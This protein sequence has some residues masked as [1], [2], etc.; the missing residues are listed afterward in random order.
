MKTIIQIFVVTLCLA[1]LGQSCLQASE[2]KIDF[3]KK[4]NVILSTK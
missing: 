1:I 2:S 4:N 3:T